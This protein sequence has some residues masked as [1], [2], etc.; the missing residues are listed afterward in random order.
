MWTY[1]IARLEELSI[2]LSYLGQLITEVQR[3]WMFVPV[4][5]LVLYSPSKKLVFVPVAGVAA[6]THRNGLIL[7]S[8]AQPFVSRNA[9]RLLAIHR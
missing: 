9:S 3:A 7:A 4:S 6:G 2:A 5:C 1:C 8:N